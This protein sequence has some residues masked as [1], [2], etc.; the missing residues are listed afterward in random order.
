M[1]KRS[2]GKVVPAVCIGIGASFN[3]ATLESIVDAADVAYRRRF[4]LEKHP[5]LA[6]NEDFVSVPAAA[7]DGA[8][9]VI[10]LV[11]HLA[12]AGGPNLDASEGI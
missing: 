11:R 10:S 3:W 1:T 6:N 8:D 4:L 5:D 12:E 2:L 9:E 7:P